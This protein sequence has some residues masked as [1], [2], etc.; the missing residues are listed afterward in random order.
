[1]TFRNT[2]TAR[3]VL[4]NAIKSVSSSNRG[5]S[6]LSYLRELDHQVRS[7]TLHD[8]ILAAIPE[9]DRDNDLLALQARTSLSGDSIRAASYR[10]APLWP[11]TSLAS[12][13]LDTIRPTVEFENGAE[14]TSDVLS[15]AVSP[16]HVTHLLE[17][18]SG[19]NL[20][21]MQKFVIQLP[22][23]QRSTHPLVRAL[24]KVAVQLRNFNESN[25]SQAVHALLR[26]VDFER[27]RLMDPVAL[28]D[29][30]GDE[31]GFASEVL[32]ETA[33]R[34]HLTAGC[35][36]WIDDDCAY[37]ANSPLRAG[38]DSAV[39]VDDETWNIYPVGNERVRKK[40]EWHD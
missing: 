5:R 24:T 30:I 14:S 29:V 6:D 16:L 1:M 3:R 7:G 40:T 34:A 15:N 4:R 21:K 39:N 31:A 9:F 35:D 12:R 28:L 10:G 25:G 36:E 11:Q 32:R 8:A 2:L 27:L 23:D 18:F 22:I 19:L 37:F 13:G 20:R 26:P 38:F 33:A 17:A